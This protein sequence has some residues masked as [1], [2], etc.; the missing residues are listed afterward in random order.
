[1]CSSGSGLFFYL[2]AG[3]RERRGEQV[4][5]TSVQGCC[6]N[7]QVVACSLIRK[8]FNPQV[9]FVNVDQTL[10][11]RALGRVSKAQQCVSK[12]VES[13]APKEEG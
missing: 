9:G 12:P 13:A 11:K 1:V 3:E 5:L 4:L 2:E 6:A 7:T 10:T 8:S